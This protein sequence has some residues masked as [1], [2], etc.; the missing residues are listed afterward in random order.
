[1]F[2]RAVA[3]SRA[4]VRYVLGDIQD[5]GQ[6][7]GAVAAADAIVHL[8]GIPTHGVVANELT[9]AINTGGTFNVHEAAWRLGVSRVVTMSSEAVLGWAPGAWTNLIL[10]EYLP[11]DEEHPTRPQDSYG[12]SKVVCEQIA[13][14]YHLKCGMEAIALRP[15]WIVSPEELAAI[16]RSN[17]MPVTRFGL[18][19]YVDV[20]DVAE[21]CCRALTCKLSRFEAVFLGSGESSVAEQLSVLYPKLVPEIGAKAAGLTGS[22]GSVSIEKAKRLLS[23]QPIYSWR[24]A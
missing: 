24:S 11:L 9:F 12:L 6:V 15:P 10:P 2:D 21:A 20:R 8:A 14:S 16:R 3:E 5:F 4:N 18:F 13:R 17:G 22:R 1:V 23:W 7:M 19:H